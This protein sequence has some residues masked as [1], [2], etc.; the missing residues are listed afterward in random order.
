M[1][2]L[3]DNLDSVEREGTL[4]EEDDDNIASSA[5]TSN[6]RDESG[7][8][9]PNYEAQKS[10]SPWD[11]QKQSDTQV[12]NASSSKDPVKIYLRKM[13]CVSMLSRANEI[14]TAKSIE[15]EENNLLRQII[16]I[17]SAIKRI[18]SVAQD[19]LEKKISL[20]HFIKSYEED[21]TLKQTASTS[22][23]LKS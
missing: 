2:S 8:D 17:P 10:A 3:K 23:V 20:R 11:E 21:E 18:V 4:Y 16:D 6:S 15:E 14:A 12:S 5:D 19:T 1:D 9:L 13:G 7:L 22:L